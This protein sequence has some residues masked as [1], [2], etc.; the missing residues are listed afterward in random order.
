MLFVVLLPL[1]AFGELDR[2]VGE[3]KVARL[4]LRPRDTSD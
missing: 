3:G 4:F 1:I 2:V